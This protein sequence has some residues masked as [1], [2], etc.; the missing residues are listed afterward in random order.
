MAAHHA[1]IGMGKNGQAILQPIHRFESWRKRS[2]LS[3]LFREE[4][5]WVHAQRI[6]NHEEPGGNLARTAA[7]GERF[8]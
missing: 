1:M 4:V 2:V 5:L 6:S 3:E 8:E 7:G